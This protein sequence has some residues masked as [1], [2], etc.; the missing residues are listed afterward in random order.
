MSRN[1]I[2]GI[3]AAVA[4]VIAAI[5]VPIVLVTGGDDDGPYNLT[6]L[7]NNDGESKLLPDAENGFPGIAR[8]INQL[9]EEQESA[10]DESDGVIT[11][12]SGDNFL[13]SKELNVSLTSDDEDLFYD[14]IALS[15]AYDA[16]ALGNHDFDFGPDV[17]ARFIKA[18]DPSIP[19]LSANSD[20]SNEPVLKELEDDDK[21]AA[22]TVIKKGGKKIG[23]IG[24]ITQ[25]LPSISSPRKVVI[26]N[27]LS[28]IQEEAEKLTEDGVEIIILVSHLQ[29]I[30][31]EL[32]LIP[33]LSNIDVVIAG[34]GDELL[35]NPGD[36]CFEEQNAL[37]V[38]AG[39]DPTEPYSTQYPIVSQDSAG[40]DV[41]VVTGPGGYRCYGRLDITFDEDG[42][43]TSWDGAATG[44]RLDGQPDADVVED[45]E[46]PLSQAVADLDT[47][48]VGTS[49]VALDGRRSNVRTVETN[50]GS[51]LADSFLWNSSE[52]ASEYGVSA[53]DIALTNGGGIRNDAVIAAGDISVSDTFDIAPFSND[54][55]V[56]EISRQ[57]LKDLMETTL[58]AVPEAGGL[59]GQI[60]GFSV[61]Y[62]A[63]AT[64]RAIDRD[65]ECAVTDPGSRVQEITL[66]DGTS[67][68][69]NGEVVPGDSLILTITD[70]LADG[71]DCYPLGHLSFTRMGLTYQQSLA[72]YIRNGLNGQ[73]TAGDYPEGGSGRITAQ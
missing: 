66:T 68:V 69:S 59:F 41:L 70:F 11:L 67:I 29:G 3:A 15:G 51:L 62:D 9:K 55:V 32:E 47:D 7:H 20:F 12:T 26:G 46:T 37:D 10:E 49:E 31:E 65:N 45:V 48:I 35:A 34:G 30:G 21:I 40:N 73:I 17:A 60:G 58:S 44:V 1:R 38:A 50:V 33:D 56:M 4:V 72:E 27:V 54:V 28:A 42:I 13:A 64:P 71:G 39:D 36:T 63:D 8:F 57:E 61:I 6:I 25:S 14:A 24:A 2:I 5:V 22:S 23:V 52:R 43:A 16:M 53:P 18:F 19:F